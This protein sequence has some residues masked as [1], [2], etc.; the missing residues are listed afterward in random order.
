[1]GHLLM[2]A[3]CICVGPENDP[4]EGVSTP[5]LLLQTTS[6]FFPCLLAV[7]TARSSSQCFP[8]SSHEFSS[9]IQQAYLHQD[10]FV[11]AMAK[12]KGLWEQQV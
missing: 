5:G 9:Q 4:S 10:W 8:W 11:P 1:M 6:F 12:A 7:H 3:T 2:A